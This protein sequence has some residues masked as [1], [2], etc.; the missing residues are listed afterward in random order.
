MVEKVPLES[1]EVHPKPSAPPMNDDQW[2]PLKEKITELEK[3][4]KDGQTPFHLACENGQEDIAEIIMKNSAKFNIELNA[5]D[6]VGRTAFQKAQQ[7]G[8][9]NVV[10]LIRSK[11]PRIAI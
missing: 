6:N 3:K 11:M 1:N 4:C 8:H 5:K 10:N 2:A 7:W 9:T